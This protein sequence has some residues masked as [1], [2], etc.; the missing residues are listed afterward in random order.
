MLHR[1][2]EAMSHDDATLFSGDVVSDEVYIGGDPANR[3]AD[4]DTPPSFEAP[5]NI[6][7]MATDKTS[8]VQVP[9]STPGAVSEAF[10][11]GTQPG[12]VR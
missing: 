10:I 12:G 9:D 7:F 3:H 1:I 11:A 6:V 4:K 5:G 8:G 2:R